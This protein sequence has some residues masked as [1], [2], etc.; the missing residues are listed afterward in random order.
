MVEDHVEDDLDAGRV[1]IMNHG[2]ELGHWIVGGRVARMR[3]EEAH[4]VVA[5][6]V[7]QAPV[8]QRRF[9]DVRVDRQQFDRGDTE[10]AQVVDDR[11]VCQPRVGAP[12]AGRDI[13]VGL[14]EPLYVQLV[15]DR[16]GP[17]CARPVGGR[18]G[19]G[20]PGVD[21]HASRDEG[22]GVASVR[23]LRVRVG[24]VE[25][26]DRRMQDKTAGQHAGVWIDE[27]LRR[28]VAQAAVGGVR[29]VCAQTVALARPDTGQVA[30]PHPAVTFR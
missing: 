11:R 20:R 15:E 2:S 26:G 4:G 8:R 16:V 18:V 22:R 17:G 28:V 3:G 30:V 13:R 19:T 10:G 24:L 21:D 14:G 7:D 12:L 1:K 29:P 9:G 5:P 6:V 23:A 27:K 25:T